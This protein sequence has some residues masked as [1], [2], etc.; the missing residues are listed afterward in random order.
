MCGRRLSQFAKSG[1]ESFLFDSL[2]ATVSESDK[3]LVIIVR[4]NSV[5]GFTC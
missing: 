2:H 3:K 1:G 4:L 5:A